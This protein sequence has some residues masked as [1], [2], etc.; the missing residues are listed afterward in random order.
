MTGSITSIGAIPPK[1]TIYSSTVYQVKVDPEIAPDGISVYGFL[2]R[3]HALGKKMWVEKL[4]RDSKD[5]TEEFSSFEELV[6][7]RLFFEYICLL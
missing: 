7:V 4:G 3:M 6:K 2:P 1:K 5:E